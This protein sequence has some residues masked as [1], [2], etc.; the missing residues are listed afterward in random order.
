M[1]RKTEQFNATR[2]YIIQEAMKHGGTVELTYS[3]ICNAVGIKNLAS[4]RNYVQSLLKERVIQQAHESRRGVKTIYRIVENSPNTIT[5]NFMEVD[6][7]LKF[8]DSIGW[9]ISKS[10][11][12]LCTLESENTFDK[13]VE[14]NL[15]L[16]SPNMVVE[17]NQTWISKA[18]ILLFLMR[19]NLDK[20]ISSKR[21]TLKKFNEIVLSRMIDVANGHIVWTEDDKIKL[22]H[23]LQTLTNLTLDDVQKVMSRLEVEINQLCDGFK[24]KLGDCNKQISA[25]EKN[26]RRLNNLYESEQKKVQ[27][28]ITEKIALQN[29]ILSK[30]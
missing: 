18:G 28:Y 8:H 9:S 16:F 22:V 12:I 24:S 27:G 14:S 17:G 30:N 26:E 19:L 1:V 3:Q 7:I 29:Q 23:N 25:H 5:V 2:D 21:E 10:D 6:V 15:E 11:L 4:A 13:I 20:I